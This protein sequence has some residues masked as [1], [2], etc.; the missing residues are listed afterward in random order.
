MRQSE[1]PSEIEYASIEASLL[2]LVPPSETV[3][4]SDNVFGSSKTLASHSSQS[5][6]IN[7]LCCHVPSLK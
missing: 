2:T 7:L 5:L 1:P 3:P 6:I 4:S